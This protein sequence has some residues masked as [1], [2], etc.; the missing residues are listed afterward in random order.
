MNTRYGA[1]DAK[2]GEIVG[3][4]AKRGKAL[5]KKFLE[6]L[7]ALKSLVEGVKSSANR[8]GYLTGLDG[9]QLHVR[10]DHAA[11]NVLLQSAGAL[12]CKKW[13][14]EF[15]KLLKENN[16][17]NVVYQ[18]A[19]VH[20]EVQLSVVEEHADEVGRFCVEAIKK[21]GDYFNIRVPLDGEFKIGR[22]WRDC[23]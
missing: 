11:L 7:P 19:W 14:V 21:A 12:V 22:S 16:L 8:K 20:D 1:G 2:I 4:N 17:H 13:L 15:H 10:S 5:K 9:R 6:T 3:G 23:H 18:M